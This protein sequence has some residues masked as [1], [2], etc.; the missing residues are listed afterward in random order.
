MAADLYSSAYCEGR[1]L[2]LRVRFRGQSNGRCGLY[3]ADAGSKN[4]AG[5][6]FQ[7]EKAA[8]ASKVSRS[9]QNA[10]P[11]ACG[12]YEVRGKFRLRLAAKRFRP[13]I[14]WLAP[15]RVVAF[16]EG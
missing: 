15:L 14:P 10:E 6:L 16:R 11:A 2:P 8:R 7:P 5:R 3:G 12:D 9:D 1:Y 13:E 4:L